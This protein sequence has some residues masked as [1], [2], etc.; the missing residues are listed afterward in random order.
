MNAEDACG[1][2]ETA[3]KIAWLRKKRAYYAEFADSGDWEAQQISGD[4]GASISRR[5]ISDK[6]NHDAIVDAI[7][8]LGGTELG[9]TGALLQSTF[10]PGVG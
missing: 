5:G 6:A 10:T 1:V 2:G 7:R 4:G 3:A 8:S 9:A